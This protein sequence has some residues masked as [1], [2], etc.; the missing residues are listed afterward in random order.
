[1]ALFL[2]DFIKELGQKRKSRPWRFSE[3]QAVHD[4]HVLEQKGGLTSSK[5]ETKQEQ[6]I[7]PLVQEKEP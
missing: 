5:V 6:V 1:V 4:D 2:T 3:R 7:W